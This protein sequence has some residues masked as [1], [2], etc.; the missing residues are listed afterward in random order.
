M[1]HLITLLI[2]LVLTNCAPTEQETTPEQ[3]QQHDLNSYPPIV[4]T[5]LSEQES[6]N[7]R[8]SNDPLDEEGPP[9]P[10]TIRAE[11]SQAELAPM[12][13]DTL[14][15]NNLTNGI[16]QCTQSLENC[17]RVQGYSHGVPRTICVVTL[18][19]KLVEINTARQFQ[20]MANAARNHGV[21][22]VINSGFRTMD[23][24]RELYHLHQCCGAPLAAYPGFSNH[25]SGI[26]LD[27]GRE[28][29]LW[30]TQN[31]SSFGF[32]RTVPSED[33]HWEWN[34]TTH[35][36]DSSSIPQIRQC[37]S[38]TLSR[39]VNA[40]TCVQARSDRQWYKCANDGVWDH[41]VDPTSVNPTPCNENFPL[42]VINEQPEVRTCYSTTL[43]RDINI[44]FCVR[45]QA[46]RLTYQCSCSE[47]RTDTNSRMI[48]V[49]TEWVQT[50]CTPIN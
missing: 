9:S 24:Q 8:I 6:A 40:N 1:K 2:V 35:I 46:D 11:Q 42:R 20:L 7:S 10:T 34:G 45:R 30:L 43:V 41:T 23:K 4:D 47:Y 25:Q 37:H 17:R 29:N 5:P 32:Y 49:Y 31:A 14:V 18:Q 19:G 33:W 16:A 22:I 38:A 15:C 48:C 13:V 27:L 26:A 39:F 21:N 44:S 28:A 3:T 12:L 50:N 36:V